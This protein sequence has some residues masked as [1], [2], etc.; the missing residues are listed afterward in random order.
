MSSDPRLAPIAATLVGCLGC[1]SAAR[2]L[3]H[4]GQVFD[5][6]GQVV[7]M[8]FDWGASQFLSKQILVELVGY[9]YRA[10]TAAPATASAAS[11]KP[12]RP[13]TI[14]SMSTVPEQPAATNDVTDS[15]IAR[16]GWSIS[17]SNADQCILAG[18]KVRENSDELPK[19]CPGEHS[20]GCTYLPSHFS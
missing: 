1:S 12:S 2:I 7:D 6:G 15:N 18:E 4:A 13:R 14:E 3:H 9:A 5:L 8:Q 19:G 16:A 20:A 10:A 17:V 11:A